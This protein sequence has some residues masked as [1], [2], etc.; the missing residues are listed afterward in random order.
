MKISY[1]W[2]SQ[3]LNLLL[4]PEELSRILTE[5]G[6]EVESIEHYKKFPSNLAGVVTG[7]IIHC[8]K[9]EHSES[10]YFTKV[11]IGNDAL[12]VV[13]GAPNV[14]LGQKVLIALPGTTL[15]P[16]QK[17]PIKIEKTTIRGYESQ[18]M[19]CAEDELGISDK[20]DGI[21]V[22]K[23]DIPI[24][25]PAS[26]LFE[27]YE[28]V[29]F[30]IS[31]T[32]NRTDALSYL[33]IAKDIA[34]AL[35]NRYSQKDVRVFPP[36]VDNFVVDN[37]ELK[38]TVT[39]ENTEACGRYS[40]LTLKDVNNGD[41]PM[42]LQNFLM[43]SGLRP[44]N[45]VVDITQFIMY[46]TG[47]PLHAFD[48][49]QIEGKL[50]I[51][52]CLPEGTIFKTLDG[53]ERKLK[54]TDLM[55]CHATDGMCMAGVMGGVESGVT[56]TTQRVFLES[57]WFHPTWIRKTARYHDLHTDAAYRFERGTDPNGTVYA[58]KR[59][60]LLIRE[61]TGAQISS[62]IVDVYPKP[63]QPVSIHFSLRNFEQFSGQSIDLTTIR[64]ILTDLDFSVQYEEEKREFLVSVP[65]YR[66][67]V[68]RKEDVYEEIL[69]IYGF[70]QIV[71][72]REQTFSFQIFQKNLLDLKSEI[73][74]FWV[75]RGFQEVLTNSLCAEKWYV[76]TG[77]ANKDRIIYIE[78]PLSTELNVLRPHMLPSLLEAA[79]YNLR[80]FQEN[81]RFFEIGKI[82]EY[83][84]ITSQDIRKLIHEKDVVALLLLGNRYERIWNHAGEKTNFY[85]MKECLDG[86]FQ[87]SQL[88]GDLVLREVEKS[89]FSYALNYTL[90][91][92]E[93][94]YIGNVH[95]SIL[96]QWDIHEEVFF[97]EIDLN[98]LWELIH[99]KSLQFKELQ[100][101]PGIRRDLA[102]LIPYHL[103]FQ[104]IS[105]YIKALPINTIKKINLFDVYVHPSWENRQKSYAIS[106]Y[107][108][109][110]ERTLHDEE[111]D[112][113]MQ[114]II[115]SLYEKWK[116]SIR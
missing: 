65:T 100:K 11:A 35:K 102:I 76:N 95:P 4:S 60:A 6:L 44:I 21:L 41:S 22:L 51:V 86:F 17:N 69:R 67:D 62:D 112:E 87:I 53:K 49:D 20:H 59:A 101:F 31:I 96:A 99:H 37:H 33:G 56:H 78:N 115:E 74:S 32:P 63:V 5:N 66:V 8:E 110:P 68:T 113:W 91:D 73:S 23:P 39:V 50:V 77:L 46:E 43:A 107:F 105:Q 45:T 64:E 108:A 106:F 111:V 85:D 13:C 10:L 18:G 98:L 90:N 48:A 12:N 116:I 103:T 52:K 97:A 15:Y 38:I 7:E 34:A 92:M 2:L 9:I 104:E 82:Y 27:N 114:M 55:I 26:S 80:H 94:A 57:A 81:L 61:L 29:V 54:A 75:G 16:F 58:L 36:S 84:D 79:S 3:Y 47:Q 72:P 1:K 71:I 70:N 30:E 83:D 109:H 88:D 19:I 14:A 40:G 28:D 24:G 42:W 25:L 93:V 89:G